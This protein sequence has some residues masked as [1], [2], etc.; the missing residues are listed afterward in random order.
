MRGSS[1]VGRRFHERYELGAVLGRGATGEVLEGHDVKLDRPV[2][3]KILRPD[4]AADAKARDSFVREARAAAGLAHPSVVAIYDTDVVDGVPYIA[5]E[6]LPGRTLADEISR[7]PLDAGTT[8]AIATQVLEGLRA[9]HEAGI[10]HRDLKPGNILLTE[11]GDAKVA[12]FGIAKSLDD[13]HTTG[14]VVGTAAYVAPERVA[15][16]KATPESDLYSLGVV[17]YESVTGEC[18]F[19]RET[20]IATVRAAHDGAAPPLPEEVDPALRGVI[21]R[22]MAREPSDRYSSASDMLSA[23]RGTAEQETEPVEIVSSTARLPTAALPVPTRARPRD[24]RRWPA[25]L[26]RPV[27]AIAIAVVCIL[28]LL[29]VGLTRTELDPPAAEPVGSTVTPAAPPSVEQPTD[30]LPQPLADAFDEL[31]DSVQR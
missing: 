26:S 13:D 28:V 20:A 6:R 18:P 30:Q 11:G 9:A 7:G 2:A 4:L 23:L 21:E 24:P 5:M 8:R 14:V 12:D 1:V 31:E 22:A 25:A 3:V 19:K 27:V 17:L 10:V 15:G 29:V 16:A